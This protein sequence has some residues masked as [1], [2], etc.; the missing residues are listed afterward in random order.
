MISRYSDLKT[1]K[2][3]N[4]KQ[5]MTSL[6]LPTIEESSDDVYIITNTTDRLD[7]LAFKYYGDARYWWV[8]AVVN[9]LGKGTLALEGGLQIRIPANPATVIDALRNKNNI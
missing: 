1:K 7:A 9:N 5:V 8:L 3:D 4:G 2:S 6:T